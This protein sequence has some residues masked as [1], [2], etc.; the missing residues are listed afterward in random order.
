[1]KNVFTIRQ[2]KFIPHVFVSIFSFSVNISDALANTIR[3]CILQLQDLSE[4]QVRY[5]CGYTLMKYCAVHLGLE[6][7]PLKF[8]V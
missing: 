8:D 3:K 2:E 7:Y 5:Y 4:Y 1:M 6:G